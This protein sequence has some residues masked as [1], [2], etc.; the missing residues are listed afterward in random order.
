MIL[1]AHLGMQAS[2]PQ[3]LVP[4]GATSVLTVISTS[5]AI[6]LAVGQA[7]FTDRIQANLP[8]TVSSNLRTQLASSVGAT[9][10]RNLVTPAELPG[11]LAAYS[12]SIT[13]VWVSYIKMD[14]KELRLTL[15]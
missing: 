10:I 12:K 14:R 2:L 15:S 7:I 8:A 13:Q 9:S 6:F 4:L 11:V 1:Q 3:A 5:C